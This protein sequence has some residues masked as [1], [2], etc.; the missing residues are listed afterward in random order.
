[1]FFLRKPGTYKP[2]PSFLIYLTEQFSGPVLS[3]R[4]WDTPEKLLLGKV[5]HKVCKLQP[6]ICFLS[7]FFCLQSNQTTLPITLWKGTGLLFITPR[8]SAASSS[9]VP[10]GAIAHVKNNSRLQERRIQP[11]TP[12]ARSPLY[13]FSHGAI[14]FEEILAYFC[15]PGH[16]DV[17]VGTV[18]VVADPLQEVGAHRHLQRQKMRNTLALPPTRD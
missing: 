6:L 15:L 10:F 14:A 4:A 8:C 9:T 7:F 12:R 13:L 16:V 11:R 5:W 3:A 1:M 2:L 18:V 17:A